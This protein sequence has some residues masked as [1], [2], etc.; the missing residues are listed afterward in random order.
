MCLLPSRSI[1]ILRCCLILLNL[2]L[3][4][5]HF[6]AKIGVIQSNRSLER[7]S[8]RLSLLTCPS[9]L[10]RPS[11][12]DALWTL[13]IQGS[14][15]PVGQEQGTLFCWTMPPSI[16][17]PRS[18]HLLR[19]APS[20]QSSWLWIR[21]LNT[22]VAW[23]K[24]KLRMFGILVDEPAFVYGDN[25][26]VLVNSSMQVSTPKTK[27][28]SIA[29]CFVQEGCAADEWRITYVNA[30]SNVADLTIK[31]LAGEKW[32]VFVKMLLHHI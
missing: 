18:C 13:V 24:Y 4:W 27:S 20:V 10:E 3:A 15:S 29:F 21:Q 25:Q 5:I 30:N 32:R 19:Q 22:C 11:Q 31:P 2:R 9:N 17:S 23:G 14:L 6:S 16:G 1:S 8:R 7:I 12:S 28:Q 26:P